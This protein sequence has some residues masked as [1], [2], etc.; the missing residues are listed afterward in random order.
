LAGCGQTRATDTLLL[1]L[2]DANPDVRRHATA[3]LTQ[4]ADPASADRLGYTLKDPDWCVRIGG[5]L[6][7]AAFGDNKSVAYRETTPRDDDE[8]VRK[9]AKQS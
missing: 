3:A 4:I 9:V 5:A 7:L 2:L 6:A 1:A 8:F